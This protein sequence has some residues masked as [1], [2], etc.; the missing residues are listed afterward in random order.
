MFICRRYPPLLI[1]ALP[2]NYMRQLTI[3]SFFFSFSNLIYWKKSNN[4]LGHRYVLEEYIINRTSDICIF[5]LMIKLNQ[6]LFLPKKRGKRKIKDNSETLFMLWE[7]SMTFKVL[8]SY[9]V[10]CI[11]CI[12][13]LT[14]I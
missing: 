11:M 6:M 8:H 14:D 10:K 2:K 9:R 3:T 5:A 7:A 1:Q 12:Y 4:I 13:T